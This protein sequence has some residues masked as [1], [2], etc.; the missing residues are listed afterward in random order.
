[1]TSALALRD[2][3]IGLLDPEQL[4]G[5]TNADSAGGLNAL[6]ASYAE[7]RSRVEQIAAYAS[8]GI[9]DDAM[10]CFVRGNLEP[11]GRGLGYG[12][13]SK[14][15]GL[16]GAI[17][18]L[19]ADHWNKA[20]NLLDIYQLMTNDR[21]NEWGKTITDMKTPPF[22]AEN[23]R[24]TLGDLM[25][26][27]AEFFAERVDGIF[28]NLSGE[29]VTNRP[30]AFGARMILAWIH[31]GS[32][33]DCRRVGYISDL[34]AV[35]AKF[36]GRDEPAWHTT[37]KIVETALRE[38]RGEWVDVDGGA[39]RLRVYLKGT[40]HV[41]VH[42]EM[43]WRLNA[44]LAYRY[45]RAIASADRTRPK[46]LAREWKPLLR[47]LPSRVIAA[48]A[49]MEHAFDGAGRRDRSGTCWELRCYRADDPALYDAVVEVLTSLG[50]VVRGGDVEFP[51]P[52]S[53]VISHV[54]TSGCVPD[55][56]SHQYYPTPAALAADVIA[57]AEIE[58]G[59]TV[60]E[61][62]AGQGAIAELVPTG[63]ELL[64]IEASPLHA[65]VL[66]A[67]GFRCLTMDFLTAAPN[68]DKFDR[69]VMNPPFQG[70]RWREHVEAA[71]ALLAPGGRL[72][73]VLPSTAPS[74]L[75]IPG[76]ATASWSEPIPFH[77]TSIEVRMLTLT[78]A[79]ASEVAA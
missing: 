5:A 22:T 37:S 73:A 39:F 70:G 44:V 30:Q 50:A 51:Y 69:I 45:P 78:S 32:Y 7:L 33:A 31:N 11:D 24:E 52:A 54:V 15:F 63:T 9:E 48:I 3:A 61:P 56:A 17:R 26:R 21:R 6:F 43:A 25:A 46:K 53:E 62:S 14:L 36:Q 41:E 23:V 66:H 75:S 20:L 59:M 29:H 34:R 68:G 47:P 2:E 55:Q 64:C 13:A 35:V 10:D 12:I 42:P 67:K 57:A 40:A 8:T 76:G 79:A 60:L 4:V 27:R 18:A 38:R 77:G 58:S 19:D 28:R 1:M 74:K 65:A 16:D 72:V 71:L 49:S